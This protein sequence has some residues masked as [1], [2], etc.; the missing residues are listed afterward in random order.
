MNRGT[1]DVSWAHSK[2][3]DTDIVLEAKLSREYLKSLM[4]Q[5]DPRCK[6]IYVGGLTPGDL[7]YYLFF[8][9]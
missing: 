6:K 3:L 2:C 1:T 5:N 4:G 7:D 9:L 8:L